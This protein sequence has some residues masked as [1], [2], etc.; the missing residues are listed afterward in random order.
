MSKHG[1]SN[2]CVLMKGVKIEIVEMSNGVSLAKQVV[3]FLV[4]F[5]ILLIMI[6]VLHVGEISEVGRVDSFR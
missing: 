1:L 5:F 2:A 3:N 6:G 4:G